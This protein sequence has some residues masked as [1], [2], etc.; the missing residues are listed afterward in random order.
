[1]R[2]ESFMS[3]RVDKLRSMKPELMVDLWLYPTEDGGREQAIG[4]GWG[5]PCTIRSEQGAG[6]IGYDGWPL[7]GEHPMRPGE[8]RRV[9][10]VFLAGKKALEYLRP[11]SKFYVWEGRIIGEATTVNDPISH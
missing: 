6:W 10:Y 3:N 9:G 5:C 1:M 2:Q 4:L 7:L 11:A 8:R